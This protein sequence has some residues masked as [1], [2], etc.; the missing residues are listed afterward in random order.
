MLDRL[1]QVYQQIKL[2][3][4]LSLSLFFRERERER[5]RKLYLTRMHVCVC[6]CVC[7][8]FCTDLQSWAD[9]ERLPEQVI[10]TLKDQGFRC[11]DQLK[12]LTPDDIKLYFQVSSLPL[13]R[14]QATPCLFVR[15]F[16][17]SLYAGPL[18][19]DSSLCAE[20]GPFWRHPPP[21]LLRRTHHLPTP[22]SPPPCRPRRPLHPT[23]LPRSSCRP[24]PSRTQ[25]TRQ[26]TPGMQRRP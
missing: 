5:D 20:I 9:R 3:F 14:L 18:L 2:F 12:T 16:I 19:R 24:T 8:C 23:P 26:A 10:T 4:F 22:V 1:A 21:P 11:V 17:F 7:V 15:D 13:L 6:L 25:A